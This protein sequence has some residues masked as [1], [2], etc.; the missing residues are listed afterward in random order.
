M[1]EDHE[2]VL[3]ERFGEIR[4]RDSRDGRQNRP[5]NNEFDIIRRLDFR[6]RRMEERLDTEREHDIA[7][8]DTL[9]R[10]NR[11]ERPGLRERRDDN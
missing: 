1:G 6:L 4:D 7:A 5:A 11:L 2:D 3:V 8:L 10:G 9:M